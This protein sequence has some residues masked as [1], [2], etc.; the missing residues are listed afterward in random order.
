M[1]GNELLH[2]T[3]LTGPLVPLSYY[4]VHMYAVRFKVNT[5]LLVT[6][7]LYL[8]ILNV[9]VQFLTTLHEDRLDR[10]KNL[11]AIPLYYP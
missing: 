8:C 1:S 5:L 6:A 7:R 10:L 2:Q 4:A 9:G 3:R 11:T